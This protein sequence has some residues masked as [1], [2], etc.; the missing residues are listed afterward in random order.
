MY[1]YIL[2]I[3]WVSFLLFVWFDTDIFIW[4]SK[5]FNITKVFKIDKWKTYRET[6]DPKITYL[7]YIL[8]YNLNFLTKLISC[9]SCLLFWIV[10]PFTYTNLQ[11]IPI[12]YFSSY[13]LYSVIKKLLK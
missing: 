6:V 3:F 9:K 7:D 5:I 13:I 12:Y 2:D 4:W 11:I 8:V 1:D 10:I